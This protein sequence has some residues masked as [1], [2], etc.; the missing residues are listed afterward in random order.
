MATV[1][2]PTGHLADLH[3]SD[4]ENL[5]DARYGVDAAQRAEIQKCYELAHGRLASGGKHI[6]KQVERYPNNPIFLNYLSTWH[7]SRDEQDQAIALVEQTTERFPDYLFARVSLAS[8][9]IVQERLDDAL[10]HLGTGL[11]IEERF[12]GREEFHI[13]EVETYEKAC[14]RYL[15]IARDLEPARERVQALR[16]ISNDTEWLDEMEMGITMGLMAERM[17]SRREELDGMPQMEFPTQPESPHADRE[18]VLQHAELQVLFDRAMDLSA[19]ELRVILALPRT[20]LMQDLR[21]I[22]QHSIDRF[23][24]YQENEE[25]LWYD[26]LSFV[27]HAVHMLG[28]LGGADAL[29]AVLLA[30]A[31][32]REY[33]ELYFDDWLTEE[34]WQPLTVLAADGLDRLDAFMR[35][36]RLHAFAKVVVA[37]AVCQ[38]GQHRPD[39]L[40]AVER[41]Y[42]G[43]LAFYSAAAPKDEVMDATQL[44]LMVGDILDLK[45]ASLLPGVEALY[46]R[47][48]VPSN[49]CGDIEK[50]RQH[51]LD[52]SGGSAKRTWLGIE[53]RYARMAEMELHAAQAAEEDEEDDRDDGLDDAPLV[54]LPITRATPKVGRNDPCP[55]GSGKKYK[56]CCD[57]KAA[58]AP[59]GLRPMW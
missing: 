20:S 47:N 21:A 5:H 35:V 22:V 33:H 15:I 23:H 46:A 44:G 40:P 18:L 42:G 49:I 9:C 48:I 24:H 26:Q 11:R 57:G 31:Q 51:L 7:Q 10:R 3:I 32:S 58:A 1:Y 19:D 56:K 38:L 13:T 43:L 41:W 16:S 25:E 30:L 8:I 14:I 59:A 2:T 45:L 12:P 28:E 50:V 27:H 4:R 39:L 6:R 17:R 52:G 36:P 54:H 55:C 29:E 53:E 34:V 37:E